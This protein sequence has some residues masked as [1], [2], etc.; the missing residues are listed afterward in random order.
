MTSVVLERMAG[1]CARLKA[2]DARRFLVKFGFPDL[3]D[4]EHACIVAEIG[5]SDTSMHII[6]RL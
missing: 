6:L 5:E 2:D 4:L 1:S 3:D